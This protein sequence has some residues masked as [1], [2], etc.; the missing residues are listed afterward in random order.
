[1]SGHSLGD[2]VSEWI[3]G[4][5]MRAR[6]RRALRPAE[7]PPRLQHPATALTAEVFPSGVLDGRRRFL[8]AAGWLPAD[9]ARCDPSAIGL[10][11]VAGTVDRLA[12]LAGARVC[13]T[14][15]ELTA[16]LARALGLEVD[17]CTPP[18][19]S[20]EEVEAELDALAD[21]LDPGWRDAGGPVPQ[22][23]Y[24][25][26]EALT[27]GGDALFGRVR[28]PSSAGL[29]RRAARGAGI[30]KRRFLG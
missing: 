9:S 10:P 21:A 17:G 24:G 1:M 2:E 22:A 27:V 4:E 26:L 8:A 25:R 18:E 23:R 7:L 11:P 19:A 15:D 3:I 30:V 28:R 20:A 12:V 5:G 16:V 13:V 14:R 29:A 6:V